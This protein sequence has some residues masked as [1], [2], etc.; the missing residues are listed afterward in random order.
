MICFRSINRAF[1]SATL[2]RPFWFTSYQIYETNYRSHSS[3][4]ALLEVSAAF[5]SVD[6]DILHRQPMSHSTFLVSSLINSFF[7]HYRSFSVATGLLQVPIWFL[8]L[9]VGFRYLSQSLYS[10]L[11]IRQTQ[12]SIPAANAVLNQSNMPT[13]SKHTCIASP[14]KRDQSRRWKRH[15]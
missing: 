13:M 12:A 6:H 2:P 9:L 15:R 8:P 1:T 10:A 14:I 3:L 5:D 11:L 7:H 4:L